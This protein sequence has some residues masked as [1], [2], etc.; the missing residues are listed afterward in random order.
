MGPPVTGF[1]VSG[2]L[3]NKFSGKLVYDKQV[4]STKD[5]FPLTGLT[6]VS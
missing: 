6:L 4:S 5:A 1:P 2:L 3:V